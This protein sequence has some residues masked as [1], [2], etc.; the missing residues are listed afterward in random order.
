MEECVYAHVRARVNVWANRIYS[1][2]GVCLSLRS[3]LRPATIALY[4]RVQ[5]CGLESASD[6]RCST[7]CC[8][9]LCCFKSTSLEN[10]ASYD[11]PAC[12]AIRQKK[13]IFSLKRRRCRC[14]EQMLGQMPIRLKNCAFPDNMGQIRVSAMHHIICLFTNYVG[15]SICWAASDQQRSA[16][17]PDGIHLLSTQVTSKLK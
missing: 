2:C 15:L 9:S 6:L 12:R 3:I 14:L 11:V 7:S 5:T 10:F 1:Q 8:F 4:L 13:D 17:F 16:R